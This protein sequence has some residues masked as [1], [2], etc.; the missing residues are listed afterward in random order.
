[1]REYDL[2]ADWY[3]SHRDTRIGLA[4]ATSFAASL[5]AG[6]R[7]L[8]IGCGNGIPMTRALLAAAHRVVGV[9]VSDEMLTRFRVNCVTAAAVA[10][11]AQSLPFADASFDAAIAWGVIF[12]LTQEDEMEAFASISRVL[13]P[14]APFLFTA[15][16]IDDADGF[17][18]TMAGVAL[19]YYSFSTDGYRA[20]LAANDLTLV[21]VHTDSWANT[22]YLSHKGR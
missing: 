14:G 1:M 8:D 20:V 13:R 3:Q 11:I 19:P 17:E 22:Y 9:D 7:V 6:A 18:D 5:A 2:I 15:G 16:R 21:D 10:G 12:H 4:E